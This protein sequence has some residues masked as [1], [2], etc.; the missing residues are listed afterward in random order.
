M[1]MIDV[2]G[3]VLEIA[4]EGKGATGKEKGRLAP[5]TTTMINNNENLLEKVYS[6]FL[7]RKLSRL[8]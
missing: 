4:N 6:E 8:H 2:Q 5:I 1:E 7:N 3:K